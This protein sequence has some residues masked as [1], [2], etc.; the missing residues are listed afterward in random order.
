MEEATAQSKPPFLGGRAVSPPN[1]RPLFWLP[2]SPSR[3]ASVWIGE[4]ILPEII[5]YKVVVVLHYAR[6]SSAAA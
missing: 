4:E 3:K 6:R 2:S 5:S 1:G